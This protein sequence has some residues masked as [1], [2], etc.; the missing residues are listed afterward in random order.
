RD[1]GYFIR[2]LESANGTFVGGKRV[3]AGREV[4]LFFGSTILLGSN[5]ELVFVP[6]QINDIPTLT[7]KTI[8]NRF[9]LRELLHPSS[10]SVVYSALDRHL[11][12][13]VAVKILSPGLTGYPGYAEQFK[14]EAAISVGL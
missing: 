7:G 10:K 9:D 3:A 8:A 14:R 5:T 13:Q 4:P 2:D 12:C 6:I 11:D 1:G